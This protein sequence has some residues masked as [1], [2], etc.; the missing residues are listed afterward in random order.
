[1]K[2]PKFG[3][4]G[5]N[6]RAH[7]HGMCTHASSMRMHTHPETTNKRAISSNLSCF[8]YIN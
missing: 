2:N 3:F 6:M 7:T 5:R 4:L 1:M 8:K